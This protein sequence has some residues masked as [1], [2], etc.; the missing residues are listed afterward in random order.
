M[1]KED[2]TREGQVLLEKKRENYESPPLPMVIETSQRVKELIKAL[3]HGNYIDK[4]TDKWL[5]LTPDLPRIP[6]FYTLAKI[7][8]PNPVGRPIIYSPTER[9]P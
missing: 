1:N 7:H 3:Y 4:M 6:V 2:K 5:S 8:K 9:I